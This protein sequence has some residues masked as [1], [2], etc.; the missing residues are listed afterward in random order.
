MEDSYIQISTEES[1]AE[2]AKL[3]AY[4]GRAVKMEYRTDA[5]GG[6]L[7]GGFFEVDEI[8]MALKCGKNEGKAKEKD[9]WDKWKKIIQN[10]YTLKIK[11]DI[12][13]V[14]M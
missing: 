9:V 12:M 4:S 1:E 13:S 11:S 7:N 8:Y 3:M 14:N 2:I 5:S 10:A 6:S